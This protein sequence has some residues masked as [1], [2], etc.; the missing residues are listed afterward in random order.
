MAGPVGGKRL[1]PHPCPSRPV[2]SKSVSKNGGGG[3]HVANVGGVAIE[4]VDYD[5]AWPSLAET[6]CTELR[7]SLPGVFTVIEHIGSTAVPGLAAKPIID[8]MAASDDLV[9][10]SSCDGLLRRLG[11]QRHD[12][13][14]PGRLFYRREEHGRRTFHLH[15]VS[16]ATWPT[17]N[18]LLLRDYLRSHPG[19]ARRYG[20]LK[21]ELA[22]R[23]D[24]SA[25]YTR[26]KTE[27]IQELTDRARAARGLPSVTVWEE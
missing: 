10:V 23:H 2:V 7:Q 18:E 17:R 3:S 9:Q 21:R 12:T 19:D 27:L 4:V 22:A 14:M 16:A 24:A 15:V 26:A 6:A 13:G 11:F 20:D 25:S 5:D 8:L 1:Q